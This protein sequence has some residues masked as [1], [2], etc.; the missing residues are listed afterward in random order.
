MKFIDLGAQYRQIKTDVDERIQA[1]LN[2]GQ[3]IKGKEVAE[4]ES[5]LADF[6]GVKHCVG[7]ANGTDALLVAMMALDIKPGDEIITPAFSYIA[8][9]EMA[10]L[11]GIVP[12]LVDVDPATY[13]LDASKL[14]QAITE[15]TKAII[16]V[17]MYGQCPDMEAINAIAAKHQLPVIED[18]AQ[19]VGATYHGQ[20]SCGL[21]TI[22]TTS[23]FPSKPLGCYGDG[24]ACFTNDEVL[25]ER[26]KSIAFHG[27][28][29]RYHH[30][31][32]GMNSRLDTLQAAVVL[33]KLAV[34][35]EEIKLRQ[36][37]A[38]LYNQYIAGCVTT[39]VVT[40]GNTSVFAQYTIRVSNR[41][42]VCAALNEAGIPTAVHYP[43]AIHQQPAYADLTKVRI[44]GDV[45]HSEQLAHEVMSLPMHPYLQESDIKHIAE[46][47]CEAAA[48]VEVL[49]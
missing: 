6:V 33:A 14:E 43:Q 38:A 22:A 1:V 7:V 9:V 25:A 2:H 34:F 46:V 12:V 15:K 47:V 28:E 48:K 23:F 49:A 44:A 30:V 26:M 5:S 13:N 45:S 20:G 35:P 40:E 31:R 10:V 32:V 42:E 37:V 17:S 24:G 8:V 21:T 39:P 3:F 27:Q 29:G 41:D 36:Q 4:L 18:G 19:S 16:P 11:Y